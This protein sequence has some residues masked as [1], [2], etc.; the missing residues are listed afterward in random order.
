MDQRGYT[1]VAEAIQEQIGILRGD[2]QEK[3]FLD[4]LILSN[5]DQPLSIPNRVR[6]RLLDHVLK[7]YALHVETFGEVRSLAVLQE[8]MG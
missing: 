4:A 7:F 8:M 6:R 5:Y 1:F 3:L 2:D